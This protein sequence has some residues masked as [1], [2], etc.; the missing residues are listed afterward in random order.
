MGLP[1][2]HK[3]I[4]ATTRIGPGLE[5]IVAGAGRLRHGWREASFDDLGT[6]PERP[7]VYCI[8]LPRTCLPRTPVLILH[9]RTFGPKTARRQ[10][11]FRFRYRAQ[12]FAA[13]RGVVVYVGKAADLRAR[14][15]GHLSDRA[16]S[17]TNQVLRGLLGKPLPKVTMRALR[18]PRERLLRHGRIHCCPHFHPDEVAD[19]RGRAN[20]G[21]SRVAERDLLEIKLIARYAPPFNIK[22]ER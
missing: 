10:L 18:A 13:G 7:G 3:P 4:A 11:R 6:V 12:H 8:T 21:E 9:G 2:R 15:K 19:P 14:L 5:R 22:A 16:R 20:M 17:T 1:G